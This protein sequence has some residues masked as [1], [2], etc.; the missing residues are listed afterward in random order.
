MGGITSTFAYHPQS[1]VHTHGH[2]L[3][4]C[5]CNSVVARSASSLSPKGPQTRAVQSREESA[6]PGPITEIK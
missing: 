5:V 4:I 3:C 6:H 1:Y 2:S